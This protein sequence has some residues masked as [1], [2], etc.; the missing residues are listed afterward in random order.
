[1]NVD[2]FSSFYSDV[3]CTLRLLLNF[4]IEHTFDVIEAA[5]IDVRTGS[6]NKN[7]E[8]ELISLHSSVMLQN[9]VNKLSENI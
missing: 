5:N 8:N 1:M 4:E 6:E 3:H 9:S 2:T 7:L